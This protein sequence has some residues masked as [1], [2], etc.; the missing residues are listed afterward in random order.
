MEK[1]GKEGRAVG[2]CEVFHGMDELVGGWGGVML[3]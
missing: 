3:H 2:H 1:T